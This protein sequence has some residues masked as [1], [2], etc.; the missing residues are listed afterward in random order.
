M[1]IAHHSYTNNVKIFAFRKSSMNIWKRTQKCVIPVWLYVLSLARS[2]EL[3]YKVNINTQHYFYV[4]NIFIQQKQR[5]CC[6]SGARACIHEPSVFLHYMH[7][8]MLLFPNPRACQVFSFTRF[9]VCLVYYCRCCCCCLM[10]CDC[11]TKF[12]VKWLHD[13]AKKYAH[14]NIRERESEIE[15]ILRM[16]W[17]YAQSQSHAAD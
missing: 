12:K 13:D 15:R 8:S 1:L 6:Y 9:V 4:C 10:V 3:I 5:C 17:I 11:R 2:L 14:T 16:C 7:M